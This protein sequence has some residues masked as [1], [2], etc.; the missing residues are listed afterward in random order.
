MES[1]LSGDWH[2]SLYSEGKTIND[3]SEQLHYLDATNRNICN[4][5]RDNKIKYVVV[6]GDIYHNKSLIYTIAQSVLLDM[7]RD[8]R[9]LTFIFL[10]GNH[11][12]SSKSKKTAS[13]L[14][15]LKSE[16]NIIVIDEPTRHPDFPDSIFVPYTPNIV[17]DVKGNSAKNL[18][19]HF[20]LNEGT[21]SSGISIVSDLKLS[22][23]KGKYQNVFLG[24]YHKPQDIIDTDIRA[25]Y[26]GSS[27]QLD[28]GE[29][30]QEKR[31]LVFNNETCEVRSVETVG[32]KKYFEYSLN[33]ENMEEVLTKAAKNKEDGHVVSLVKT[34]AIDTKDIE[35]E[36]IVIDRVGKDITNRG[37]TSCM[38]EADKIVRYLEINEISE[39]EREKYK[40]FAVDI[41]NEA[42]TGL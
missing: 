23:L 32:Y 36:Y 38:T 3:L 19:S 11:D 27:I 26:T 25:Y 13:T 22:D 7:V 4:Y 1:I 5:A 34:N 42:E 15:G 12:L 9:D 35:K 30:N 37:I 29:K 20:G 28:L 8:Y 24:H 39:I 21:L 17:N 31:F 41:I 33:E 10:Q 18:F 2:Y 40:Q 16:E 6:L 14:K